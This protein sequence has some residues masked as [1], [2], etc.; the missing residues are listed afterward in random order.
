M[1]FP[2]YSFLS[3]MKTNSE[4][5]YWS[6]SVGT[7]PRLKSHP[8]LLSHSFCLL[9]GEHYARVV[10]ME[11][12]V[13]P[14]P[15]LGMAETCLALPDYLRLPSFSS[16]VTWPR[17]AWSPWKEEAEMQTELKSEMM[18]LWT[19]RNSWCHV[20][21]GYFKCPQGRSNGLIPLHSF[22]LCHQVPVA[23]DQMQNTEQS[24]Q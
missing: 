3:Q 17:E 18:S 19:N 10:L 9:W 23:R 24:L 15:I 11:A 8:L 13:S 2:F 1:R 20:P 4:G 21:G 12:F 22:F 16:K 6:W 7:Y 5:F 14:V